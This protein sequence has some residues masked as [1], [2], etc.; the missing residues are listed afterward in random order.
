MD[1]LSELLRAIRLTGTAFI[2]AQLSAPWAVET[3]PP[4]AIA[5]RLASKAGRII[6][7][8]VVT[9]GCCFVELK[10]QPPIKLT[11]DD[12]VFFPHGDVHVLGS[13][14]GL[15]PLKITTDA[16]L[17][18]TRPDSIAK[19]RHGGAGDSTT[20]VCG[21]FACDEQLSA[22]L[23]ER[24]PRVIRHRSAA[25][26]AGA[27][28]PSSGRAPAEAMQPGF[29][30]VL[31]KL[32]ELVFVDAIRAYV[33][34][35]PE[36]EG[37]LGGL[38][39]RCVSS[40]LAL[41]F[42]RPGEPWT[43]ESLARAAGKSRT[44]LTDHFVRCVGAAPMHFLSQ[45]RLRIAADLLANSDRATKLI[46]ESA[47]FSSTAAFTRAFRREFGVPPARWRQHHQPATRS[48]TRS[49]QTLTAGPAQRQPTTTDDG[50]RTIATPP[51]LRDS[52][53]RAPARSAKR[54]PSTPA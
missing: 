5:A 22:Q 24:L 31:A 37:W 18:L 32:S 52:R 33:E 54:R 41:I 3:P 51:S 16:V 13:R 14:T 40:G 23:I 1:G 11:A 27:L 45:W 25:Y 48:S 12:A 15:K 7:Y 19:T 17:K 21:F 30:A 29:G 49:S 2:E 8:H 34:S 35:L 43:L 4:S 28:L 44:V 42:G 36:Q 39:D 46:A 26:S 6:P 47:G 53:A 9:E 10:G 38:R 50:L 20:L